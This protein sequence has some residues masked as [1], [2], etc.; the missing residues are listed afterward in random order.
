MHGC[1]RGGYN[2]PNIGDSNSN[3]LLAVINR[4][5]PSHAS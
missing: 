4:K 2:L 5:N 3:P 1:K